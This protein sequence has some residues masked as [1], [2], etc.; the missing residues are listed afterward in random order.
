MLTTSFGLAASAEEFENQ[1]LRFWHYFLKAVEDIGVVL[2]QFFNGTLRTRRIVSTQLT[3]PYA[4]RN[5]VLREYINWRE[6]T[7]AKESPSFNE[8]NKEDEYIEVDEEKARE[9]GLAQ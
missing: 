7:N 5:Y 8:I 2:W 4:G 6:E 9:L 3:Q 1:M